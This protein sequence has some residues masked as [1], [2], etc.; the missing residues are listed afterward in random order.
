MIIGP[1]GLQLLMDFS[2]FEYVC[3]QYPGSE[4][5]NQEDSQRFYH[6]ATWK[7]PETNLHHSKSEETQ[8]DILIS[9]E[10]MVGVT[11]ATCV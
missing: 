3:V 6:T 5:L 9:Q 11:C 8:S 2:T 7:E 4:T 1:V 10:I